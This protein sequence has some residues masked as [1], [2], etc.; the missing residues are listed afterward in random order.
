MSVWHEGGEILKKNSIRRWIVLSFVGILILSVAM[1]AVANYHEA[2]AAAIRD[3]GAKAD[4]FS[5]L[6]TQLMNH[7]WNLDDPGLSPESDSYIRS[8]MA[9]RSLC[10]EFEMDYAS[11]YTVDPETPSRF[12]YFFVAFDDE[13]DSRLLKEDAL[14]TVPTAALQPAE[15]ALMNGNRKPQHAAVKGRFEGEIVWFAPCL[16]EAGEIR[17]L[18]AMDYAEAG[19]R[20]E[21]RHNF[22]VDI[23]PFSLSLL[24][25]M[26]I[27]LLLV[28]RRITGPVSALS[29]R[30][31]L[32]APPPDESENERCIISLASIGDF[33]MLMTGDSLKQAELDLV[34]K[35]SLPDTEL[36]IVGH[37]G[38]RTSTDNLFLETIRAEDAVISVGSNNSYGHP[39]REVLAR[40]QL[41][42]CNIWRTD[43]NGTVEIR[44]KH[45]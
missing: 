20:H 19:L 1:S 13:E 25:G 10:Q 45:A 11:V 39:N 31:K 29:E 22:L 44:V 43:R 7:E 4:L 12:Y 38:S 42:G 6:V 40:L 21:I 8:R 3:T 32:F 37:H 35:Y 16:D 14:K 28:H 18:V 33:D 30:M 5:A 26:L 34:E 24:T 2:Y 41:H 15:Q 9:F 27:L 17:A 36:L 23:I